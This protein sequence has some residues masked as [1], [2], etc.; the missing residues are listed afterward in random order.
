MRCWLIGAAIALAGTAGAIPPPPP[1]VTIHHPVLPKG[2]TMTGTAAHA[3][4][5]RVPPS[6]TRDVKPMRQN[7]RTQYEWYAQ[8]NGISVA[9]AKKRTSEQMA[10]QP[11]LERLRVRLAAAEPHNYVDVRMVH[12]PDWGYVLFFKRDPE[13]TL[14]KY[15]VHPRFRAEHAAL[16]TAELQKLAEP[17]VKRFTEAGILA[18]YGSDATSGKVEMMMQVSEAEYR[19][20]ALARN[21]G[22][23]PGPLK[24]GF[25]GE[26]PF[27]R[28]DP[29]VAPLLR[30]FA[31]ETRSTVIQLE[32][33]YSG[34]VIL[35]DGCL[36]LAGNGKGK[37]PLA[38][39][40]RETGIGLDSEGYLAAIDRRTGKATGRIG[41][42]WSWAGP[43]GAKD[44]DGLAELKAACGDG[45]V[46]NVGNPESQARFEARYPSARQ[47]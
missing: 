42:E 45:P 37:G 6:P 13:A 20:L 40:H 19:T 27:P 26:L 24:L 4:I 7:Y 36:R 47:R 18:G 11:I 46:V 1:P 21:W 15:S 8:E 38:V 3:R 39:F 30:G 43:N 44:Y 41:E 16:T 29:R 28:V 10:V 2:A 33:G 32:A 5:L 23:L 31:S 17:W 12:Q 9:E 35:D 22:T 34:R 14:R 25:A